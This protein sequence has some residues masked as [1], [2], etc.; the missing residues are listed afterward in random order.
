MKKRKHVEGPRNVAPATLPLATGSPAP[1]REIKSGFFG[2]TCTRCGMLFEDE[3][4][5]EDHLNGP[6]CEAQ[7]NIAVSQPGT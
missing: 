5:A 1:V 7:E 4:E 2:L 3:G 6:V